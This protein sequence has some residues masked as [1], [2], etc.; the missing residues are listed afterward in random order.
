VNDVSQTALAPRRI[1][2]DAGIVRA[3]LGP[4]ALLVFTPPA[5]IVL[6]L[7]CVRFGGSPLALLE[8]VNDVGPLALVPRPTLTGLGIVL[9]FTALQYVLLVALPGKRF[10]GPVTPT[11]VQ[12]EYKLN[13]VAA[14]AITHA[15]LIGGF[16]TGV[17][18][19]TALYEELGG[20]LALLNVGALVVC[21]V[22]YVKGRV[23]PSSPDAVLTGNFIFDFFQG[24]ELHPRAFGVSLKQ[25]INCRVS[26]MAW[27]SMCVAYAAW[28]IETRG[29]LSPAL[30]ASVFLTV[31]YL[32]K[33]FW[34][35]SGYFTSLDIMHDRFGF[36]ICWGVLVW[37]PAVYTSPSLY[38]ASNPSGIGWPGA[39]AI[40][41]LGL[42]AIYMNYAADAQRQRVRE[43]DGKANVFG[44][45]PTIIRA[46]YVTSDGEERE[47]ILLA[48]GYWGIA[49]HFHYVPELTA[50]LA[51]SLPAGFAPVAYFYF[52]FLTILLFDR[53]RRDDG[54]CR[55][56][57]GSYWDEYR[58]LVPYKII[59]G[60]Y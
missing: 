46:R 42:V 21:F 53:A 57:Y 5:T 20:I 23:A 30:F 50:A 22:L 28:E 4:L 52:V 37:V 19:R 60:V 44:K 31:V 26:M 40:V 12:P 54:R 17:L 32:L 43:S 1:A 39:L 41:A 59:P 56:K 14:W 3:V 33:F 15:L 6:W 13:G 47:S 18:S 10:L 58:G 8:A 16:A 35:E 27:S 45:P 38:I 11:G 55:A 9:G 2:L 34:W 51:W 25:L 24:V 7:L 48:S 36:Y 49:R 29:A